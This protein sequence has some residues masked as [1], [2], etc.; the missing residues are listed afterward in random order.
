MA[1]GLFVIHACRAQGQGPDANRHL[2]RWPEITPL[3]NNRL[4]RAIALIFPTS[5]RAVRTRKPIF[6]LNDAY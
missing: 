4:L 2:R 5:P 6:A 1:D 3:R